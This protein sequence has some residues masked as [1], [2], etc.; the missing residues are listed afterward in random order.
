MS[1]YMGSYTTAVSSYV[2]SYRA[3][4]SSYTTAMSSYVSSYKCRAVTNVCLASA[5]RRQSSFLGYGGGRGTEEG[6]VLKVFLVDF[7][8]DA[9]NPS[10]F[11]RYH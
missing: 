10:I 5:P 3:A 8:S 2:T 11:T 1:S 6:T 4:M 9:Y 7:V